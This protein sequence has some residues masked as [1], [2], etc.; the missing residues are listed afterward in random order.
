MRSWIS[1]FLLLS[2]AAGVAACSGEE[3]AAGRDAGA[4]DAERF[5]FF[6][7]SFK[8]LQAL[9]GNE[10]GF[11]GDLRYGE[12]GAGAGLR[13]ADKICSEIAEISMPG[14]SKKRW[15]AFLSAVEGENGEQVNA[16]DRIGEG[17]WYDRLGRVFALKKADL[18]Q[19]R[20]NGIDVAIAHDFTNEEGIPNQKPDPNQPSVDNHDILT[21]TNDK[22]QLYSSTATCKDWT[23]A[24]GD[25]A[26]EGRPRVGHSWDRMADDLLVEP[27]RGMKMLADGGV[28]VITDDQA[29]GGPGFHTERSDGDTMF[30]SVDGGMPPMGVHTK[31]PIMIGGPGE[32]GHGSGQHWMS[33]LDEAG[34]APGANLIQD[35]PPKLANPTVGSGGGYG[36][37]YCFASAP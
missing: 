35:G 33:T 19:D 22:G 17:P 8:S 16:I 6:V 10:A 13:G 5:S 25:P 37:I 4:N 9:S 21:G 34:C 20:P 28:G 23:S 30:G 36:G 24:L 14:A 15:R 7:A 32:A 27:Q 31:G 12:T 3:P 1:L 11:G 29:D 26:T 2:F 18:F